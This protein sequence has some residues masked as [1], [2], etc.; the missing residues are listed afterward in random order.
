[1]PIPADE[2]KQLMRHWATGVT[3]VT[4]K[5]PDGPHGMT[6]NSFTG[7]SLEP[8]LIL[9]S[10]DRRTRT[11][12]HLQAGGAFG[13]HILRAGQEELSRRC[14]GQ[15]GEDGNRL[16][17]VSYQVSGLGVPILDD[18]LAALECRITA[19]YD[20]GDHTIFLAEVLSTRTGAS[21]GEPLLYF[22]RDYRRIGSAPGE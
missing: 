14:A 15:L 20:G 11:H 6:A 22:D 19:I 5:G 12:E 16:A 1:M 3:V 4:T 10:V 13:V 21:T 9:V 7:V 8:P 18:C 2:Y 17:G